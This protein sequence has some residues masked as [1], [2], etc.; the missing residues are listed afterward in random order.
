MFRCLFATY[1]HIDIST[2]DML[3]LPKMFTVTVTGG[4]DGLLILF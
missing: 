3:N 1:R 2:D 4:N